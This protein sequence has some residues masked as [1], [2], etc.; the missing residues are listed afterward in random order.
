MKPKVTTFLWFDHDAEEAAA[1]YVSVFKNSRIVETN[2]LPPARPGE[3]GKVI[4]VVF[5]LEGQRFMAL[6]GGPRY[7]LT[8]AV[9]LFVSC[10]DQ[11]EVDEL[12][13]TLIAEGGSESRCGWLRD[14]FGLSWQIIPSVLMEMMCDQDPDKAGRVMN[15]LLAMNKIDIAALRRAHAGA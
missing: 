2:R 10:E 7:K 3:T 11:R 12:W 13:A 5:E 6:N 4:T 14:R 1:F 8:D 9:S 15:A